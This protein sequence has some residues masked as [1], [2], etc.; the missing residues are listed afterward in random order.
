MSFFQKTSPLK[1]CSGRTA[2]RCL[3]T[4]ANVLS[5]AA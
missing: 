5:A 3:Q 4:E 2:E 1:G